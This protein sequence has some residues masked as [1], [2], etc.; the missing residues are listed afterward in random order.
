MKVPY[1]ITEIWFWIIMGELFYLIRLE[2][3]KTDLLYYF[4]MWYYIYVYLFVFII[5][6]VNTLL[7][8]RKINAYPRPVIV[9]SKHIL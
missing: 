1:F 8:D 3:F 7:W 6:I 5:L 4:S 9:F 2:M